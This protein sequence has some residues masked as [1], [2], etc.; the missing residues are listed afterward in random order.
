M[1]PIDIAPGVTNTESK[2][3]GATNWR[4][5]NMI[6]WEAN[7]LIPIPG[8]EEQVT[9]PFASK[10]REMHRWM[11]NAGLLVTAYLCERHLYYD[12]GENIVDI[13][14]VDGIAAPS[15][16]NGGYG[17]HLYSYGAFGTARPGQSRLLNYTPVYTLDNWGDELRAMT[18]ADGRLLKW[19][20]ATPATPA[21]AVTNAPVN[22]RTFVITPERHIMLFGYAGKTDAFCW[23]DEEDDTNWLFTDITSMAGAFDLEPSSPIVAVKQFFGGIAM[24]TMAAI[25]IIRYT[26]MP[27]IYGYSE[28]S[29]ASVPLT[30][31]SIVETPEGILWPSVD[32]FWLCTGNT[33]LPVECSIWDWIKRNMDFP[34]TAFQAYTTDMSN[35]SEIWWHFVGNETE[36][37]NNSRTVIYDYRAKWWSMMRMGRSCGFVYG[38][39]RYPI[40]SDGTKVYKHGSGWNYPG[41]E[42]PWAESYV[43]NLNQGETFV[44]LNEL[45]PEIVGNRDALRFSL[46]KQFDRTKQETEKKTPD[47]RVFAD[48]RIQFRETAKDFRIRIQ[49]VEHEP[50]S[51]GPMLVDVKT[52]GRKNTN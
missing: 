32:G 20:P 26:G 12:T 31:A 48:G 5:V 7:T 11:T 42:M 33:L 3:R 30:Q 13:T 52:R 38:P 23:C 8:W 51:V 40:M 44:T 50:W 16:N 14:P 18:S 21:V 19:N 36:Q 37:F 15:G 25:Y 6:R 29:K 35:Q 49:M 22:N 47:R 28:L 17:D 46:Y 27:Y 45:Q 2:V 43:M 24:F 10:L 9:G 34:S 1:I 39:D 41:A 4:E